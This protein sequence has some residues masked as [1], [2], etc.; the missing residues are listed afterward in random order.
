MVKIII[1]FIIFNDTTAKYLPDFLLSLKN[2]TYKDFKIIVF[3]N[4][5]ED[6]VNLKYLKENFSEIE[7]LGTGENIG[8]GRAYNQLIKKAAADGAEYFFI[9]LS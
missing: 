5:D 9:N 3:N 6:G 4:G 8:F 2:Q 7:I 1:G